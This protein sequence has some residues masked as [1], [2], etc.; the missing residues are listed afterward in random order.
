MAERSLLERIAAM[1]SGVDRAE[2]DEQ[3]MLGSVLEHLNKLFNVRQGGCLTNPE[4]G[5]PDFNDLSHRFPDAI[6]EIRRAVKELIS[7]YEPRL[8][9][10]SVR[11]V[12][13]TD[14]PLSLKF[15]VFGQ[16]RTG[17]RHARVSMETVLGY[18]GKVEVKG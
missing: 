14:A 9:K 17:N 12:K 7:R 3:L 2:I 1:D 15:E 8:E 11:H 5:L 18:D 4:L 10:V 16:L 6:V 13:E